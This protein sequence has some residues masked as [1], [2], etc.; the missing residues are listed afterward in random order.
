MKPGRIIKREEDLTYQRT[1]SNSGD[2]KNLPYQRPS[3]YPGTQSLASQSGRGASQNAGVNR[4]IVI[5]LVWVAVA[6]YI[7]RQAAGG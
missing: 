6:W 7:L 2:K 5:E 1:L 3:R 4:W